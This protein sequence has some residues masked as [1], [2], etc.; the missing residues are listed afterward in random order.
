MAATLFIG[1]MSTCENRGKSVSKNPGTSRRL[2]LLVQPRLQPGPGI[3]PLPVSMGPGNGQGLSRFVD[4]KSSKQA[5]LGH[6]GRVGILAAQ[7]RQR[8]VQVEDLI[9]IGLRDRFGLGEVQSFAFAAVFFGL[10]AAGVIDEDAAHGL[11][12]GGDEMTAAIP[13]RC[14]LVAQ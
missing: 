14:A 1:Y 5:E 7:D 6:L 11:G 10:L 8:L 12:G 3:S 13:V 9:R 2:R 4:G